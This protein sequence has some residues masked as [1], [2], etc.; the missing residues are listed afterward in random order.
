MTN[1][2]GGQVESVESTTVEHYGEGIPAGARKVGGNWD[3]RR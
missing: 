2:R 1:R 3:T